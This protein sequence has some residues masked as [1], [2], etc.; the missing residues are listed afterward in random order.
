MSAV[1][2]LY[3]DFVCPFCFIAE[4]ST[5]PRLLNEFDLTLDWRGFELHRST[6]VGGKPLS[7]LF[8]GVDLEALHARTLAFAKGFGVVD[9]RPPNWLSNT[10]KVLA[11]AEFARDEGKLE[12]FRRAAFSA[13]FREARDLESDATL[14]HIA[15]QAELSPDLALL[16]VRD[17]KYFE[18]VDAR[19][20]EA[21]AEGVT[22]IPTFVIGKQRLV[23][24][25]PYERMARFAERALSEA[26]S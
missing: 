11:L 9:F 6:P 22:G 5:V 2:S 26:A 15:A 7:A 8:P 14:R 24:C 16:A 20:E 23:G 10:R 25:Q 13:N 17:S 19:Q 3:T 21:R 18:R 4:E 1:L 12:P